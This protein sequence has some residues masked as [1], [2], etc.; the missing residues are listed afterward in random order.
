MDNRD[1]L[2]NCT[3]KLF[4]QRGFDA[5]GVREIVEAAGVTKPTLYHY[6]S[7]KR[8]L[9]NALLNRETVQWVNN[10]MKASVYQGDIVITLTNITRYFFKFA[11]ENTSFYR[12]QL[13]MYTSPPESVSN[14][15]IRPF[16]NQVYEILEEVFIQ[17][18]QDHG[19][20][21]GRHKRYAAGF[22]GQINAVVGLYLNESF[23]LTDVVVYE[24]VHQFMHGIFS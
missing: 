3:L 13:A 17:A 18:S 7:S 15:A 23:D 22:L 10:L 19:N 21:K 8:G 9:L 20:F 6:F 4:S 2:L 5:V 11:Q 14:Q 12:M 16:I 1:H 24:T